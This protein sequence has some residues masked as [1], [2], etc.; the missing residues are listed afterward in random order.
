MVQ[1]PVTHLGQEIDETEIR[2]LLVG[3]GGPAPQH[4]V[5]AGGE[6]VGERR[7]KSRPA[8]TGVAG[9]HQPAPC[10]QG[11]PGTVQDG[12]AVHAHRASPFG[13]LRGVCGQ[14]AW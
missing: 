14:G 6:P 8:G 10:A 12:G 9:E 13:V 4:P 2:Q 3:G 1:F 11:G 7:Q 5:A